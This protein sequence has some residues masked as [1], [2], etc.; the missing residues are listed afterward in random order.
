MTKTQMPQISS[1]ELNCMSFQKCIGDYE[2]SRASI[3]LNCIIVNEEFFI[4]ELKT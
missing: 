1:Y 3:K 2:E 4:L